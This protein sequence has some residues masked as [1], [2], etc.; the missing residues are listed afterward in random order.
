MRA[1]YV[2]TVT[3]IKRLLGRKFSELDV[4][5]EIQNYLGYK[6]VQLDD[7]EIGIQVCTSISMSCFLDVS[8]LV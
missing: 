1:N 8:F 2:N 6:V 3:Q 4:Q 5:H 7:D